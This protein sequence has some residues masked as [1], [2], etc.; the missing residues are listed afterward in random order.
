[1]QIENNYVSPIFVILYFISHFF[2]LMKMNNDLLK[3]A[4]SLDDFEKNALNVIKMISTNL[5]DDRSKKTIEYQSP[6]DE[7]NYWQKDFS[8]TNQANLIDIL[9]NVRKTSMNFHSNGYLGHQVA[10]LPPITILTSAFITY[11]N[12]PIAVYEVGM[13]GISMEKIVIDHLIEKFG[14]E[15]GSTGVIISGGSMGN[16]TALITARTSSGIPETEY[17]RL[18][19]M[20]SEEAHYSVSRSASIIGI[21]SGN[22]I[23]I[24]V[25]EDCSMR[26]DLLEQI[27][28]NEISKSKIIFCI[29][30]CACTTSVGAYD[31]LEAIGNFAEKHQIWF[32]VDGAHGGPAIFSK[33]YRHLLKGVDS[34]DSISLDF[35]KMMLAPPLSTA[36]LYNKKNKKINE[37]SP[38]A[39]YLWQDQLSQEWYNSAKHTLECTKPLTVLHTYAI[40]KIY[41]DDIYE[42][43]VDTLFDLGHRFADLIKS[44][45]TIEL[46]LEPLTN[47][48]C[49]RYIPE[50]GNCNIDEINKMISEQ[51]LKDGT[52]YVVST[53][54]H[55]KFYL[56]VTFMNPLVNETYLKQL[57]DN[58]EEIGKK[59]LT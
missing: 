2:L 58:I 34:S 53:K 9:E 16:L 8:S 48:V 47:I 30:G 22:I 29:V 38:R 32:H 13:A 3:N 46:A 42:Q 28:Q 23:K 36:L 11:L 37:F 31:D 40:M 50:A 26:T 45:K 33:K 52:F 39:D 25:N 19:I 14:Y 17:H 18:A 49:F 59:L 7:L 12:N 1:M 15:K 6:E 57:L 21:R 54:I 55:S 10:I 44:R 43:N 27:Y 5:K 20:V 4:Y 24:P 56:R 41:G 35:H 51:L